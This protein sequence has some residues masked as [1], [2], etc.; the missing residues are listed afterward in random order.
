MLENIFLPIFEATI[1]PQAHPDL[2]IFLKRVSMTSVAFVLLH[3]NHPSHLAVI[4]PWCLSLML[5]PY[6]WELKLGLKTGT[7]QSD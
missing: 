4:N 2:S 7:L 1:N 3:V 6:I 5:G